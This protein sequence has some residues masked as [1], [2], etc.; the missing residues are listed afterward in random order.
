MEEYP[1]L[2]RNELTSHEKNMEEAEM[3]ITELKRPI[4]KG[5]R[6]YDSSYITF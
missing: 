6:A 1:M 2:K 5:H 4:W 3:H